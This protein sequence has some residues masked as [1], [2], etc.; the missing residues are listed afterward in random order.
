MKT[1]ILITLLILSFFCV[2]VL[3]GAQK[4]C[5]KCFSAPVP[6]GFAGEYMGTYVGDNYGTFVITISLK[7]TIKG[8]LTLQKGPKTLPINGSCS[9]KGDC[10]FHSPEEEFSFSGKIDFSCKMKGTWSQKGPS[11]KGIFI[12][13][14]IKP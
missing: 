8:Y 11:T 6:E 2:V 4:A 1:K 5:A 7:G 13:V 12:A 3:L 10:E 9:Y 14:K